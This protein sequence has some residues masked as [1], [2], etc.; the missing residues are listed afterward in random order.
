MPMLFFLIYICLLRSVNC[1]KVLALS[2]QLPHVAFTECCL[3]GQFA[4]LCLKQLK[5][6]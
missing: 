3:I 2:G 6:K 1:L 5:N 4:K